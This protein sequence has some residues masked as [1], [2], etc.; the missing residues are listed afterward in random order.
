MVHLS[1][2]PSIV[3]SPPGAVWRPLPARPGEC[4]CELRMRPFSQSFPR[5]SD[6]AL[7]YAGLPVGTSPRAAP[8]LLI[9]QPH[10]PPL[11]PTNPPP[12]NQI[13]PNPKTP[14]F[15]GRLRIRV[16]S[17][18]C[19]KAVRFPF[20]APRHPP[21]V[22]KGCFQHRLLGVSAADSRSGADRGFLNLLSKKA[23][24]HGQ[25]GLDLVVFLSPIRVGPPSTSR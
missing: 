16:L 14:H 19:A 17:L 5:L 20:C 2:L 22:S 11:H 8:T 15:R 6:P 24:F 12:P 25:S 23:R 9:H 10:P 4:Y 21:S 13:P 7:R 18:S 3:P 1:L